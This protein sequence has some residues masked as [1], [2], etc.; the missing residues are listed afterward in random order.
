MNKTG[1]LLLKDCD[2]KP[3]V[4]LLK[5]YGLQLLIT[6]DNQDIPGSYWGDVEAGLI[7]N[8][9]YVRE[10]TPIHSLLHESC[11]YICMDKTRRDALDTDAGGDYDEENGVCCLQILLSNDL[12]EMGQS[13]MMKDMDQWG[14]TFREG[15]TKNWF[16]GDAVDAFAWLKKYQL[17]DDQH[18]PTYQLR[19]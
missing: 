4:A 16:Q 14:Y 1:A 10:D 19:S 8:K 12:K 5:K 3:I 17:I 9:V 13:R 7:A 11:H 6:S 15:S 18:K 2:Q